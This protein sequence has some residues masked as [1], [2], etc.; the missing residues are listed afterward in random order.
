M[1][2]SVTNNYLFILYVPCEKKN[3]LFVEFIIPSLF[4]FLFK[5]TKIMFKE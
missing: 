2:N 4:F 1:V 3:T 5:R